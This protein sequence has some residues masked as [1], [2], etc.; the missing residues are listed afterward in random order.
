M[1]KK[2][3]NTDFDICTYLKGINIFLRQNL[4]ICIIC[5]IVCLFIYGIKIFAYNIGMDTELFLAYDYTNWKELG[6]YGLLFLK[7]I[8]FNNLNLYSLNFLSIV[9][10]LLSTLHFVYL[11]FFFS[12]SINKLALLVFALTYI[13]SGVWVEHFYFTLQAAEVSIV[14]FTIPLTT[15]LLLD[16]YLNKKIIKV[17]I[18]I[19][20]STFYIFVY[21]SL[22][23]F[24]ALSV[25]ICLIFLIGSEKLYL[26]DFVILGGF[27]VLS[28]FAYFF[29]NNILNHL[30]GIKL[31]SYISGKSKADR[32]YLLN[33]L[34]YCYMLGFSNNPIMSKFFDNFMSSVART[35]NLAVIELHKQAYSISNT[36]F[37]PSIVIYWILIFK[38]KENNFFIKIVMSLVPFSIFLFPLACGGICQN[39]TQLVIPLSTAF[40]YY[41]IL[42]QLSN[43]K[44]IV[45]LLIIFSTLFLQM[46]RSS[47]LFY[48][49]QIRFE[50]D[51]ELAKSI[52]KELNKIDTSDKQIFLYGRFNP[53]YPGNFVFGEDMGKSLFNCDSRQTLTNSTYRG[54]AFMNAL[55][56]HYTPVVEENENFTG[57]RKLSEKMQSY[58]NDGYVQTYKNIVIVKLSDD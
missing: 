45:F 19:F 7:R 56:F 24:Y 53:S 16:G 38:N 5:T 55:G 29:M 2:I 52:N 10:L 6:R 13:S 1:N 40:M 4:S 15:I 39:R 18:S 14:I 21:Q 26:K 57:A 34:K 8:C 33:F 22:I 47:N 32:S 58:P 41:F 9:F 36:A 37:Y 3:D 27:L 46:Q 28:I 23:I 25:Y 44:R 51:F 42:C 49:D 50:S 11:I 43:K 30:Y 17:I 35:G 54:I 12:K 31:S 20:I 48:S